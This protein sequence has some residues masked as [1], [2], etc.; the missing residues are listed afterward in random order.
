MICGP[1]LPATRPTFP[2][3]GALRVDRV[4]EDAQLTSDWP[5]EP[6]TSTCG[7]QSLSEPLQPLQ[8]ET[9][10]PRRHARLQVLTP[11]PACINLPNDAY[12]CADR[13]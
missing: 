7:A 13:G 4:I 3:R 11:R 1:A 12:R 8:L 9:A 6:V 2:S 10:T 5:V